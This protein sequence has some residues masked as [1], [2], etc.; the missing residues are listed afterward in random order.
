MNL[1]NFITI[2]RITAAPVLWYLIYAENK[3]AFTWLITAA[4]FTDLIDGVIARKTH[5]VTRL[6]SKLDSIG[7]SLTIVTGVIGLAFFNY[8]LVY[9]HRAIIISVLVLH[10]IQL[11]LSLWRYGKVSSFHTWSAKTAAMAVG[12]FI[13]ITLHFHF[14]PW[15]FYLAIVLLIVDG[16][17]DC[18]LV[19]MFPEWKNDVK[20]IYWVLKEKKTK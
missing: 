2:F 4:F 3:V 11:L 9:Q 16:I 7:D 18:I 10:F 19:F 12:V 13:L 6:G 8:D 5:H 17:E 20:G 15:L 14:I 1:P